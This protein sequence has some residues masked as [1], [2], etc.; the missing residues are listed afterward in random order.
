MAWQLLAGFRCAWFFILRGRPWGARGV[1]VAHGD[2]GLSGPSSTVCAHLGACRRERVC[3]AG[4]GSAWLGRQ[5]WSLPPVGAY[6]ALYRS[7]QGGGGAAGWHATAA[8]LLAFGRVRGG[9][10]LSDLLRARSVCGRW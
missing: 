5:G 1:V 3:C 6:R 4:S 7:A 9:A 2:A 8:W 10:L